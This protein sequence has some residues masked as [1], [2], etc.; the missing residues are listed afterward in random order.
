MKLLFIRTTGGVSGA[1]MYNVYLLKALQKVRGV[2]VHLLTNYT[3]FLRKLKKE[4]IPASYVYNPVPEA[5]TN[6]ELLFSILW[7]YPMLFIYL[8]KIKEAEHG[9]RF[10]TVVLE[11][12]TEKLFLTPYLRLLGYR[13]VW[14]EHGPLFTTNRSAIVKWFYRYKS[15]RPEAIIAVSEDTKKDLVKGGVSE[16]KVHAVHIGIEKSFFH[17][18]NWDIFNSG[19]SKKQNQWTIGFLGSVSKEKGIFEFLDVANTLIQ[20]HV[21]TK[22]IIIGNGPFLPW[23]KEKVRSLHIQKNVSFTGYVDDVK[24]S[25]HQ[26]DILFFPTRHHEG[27]SLALLEALAMGKI[28]LARDI[29]GNRELVIDKKTGF[30]FKGNANEGYTILEKIMTKK[31]KI[32]GIAKAAKEHITNNFSIEKQIHRFIDIFHG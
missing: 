4:R 9:I 25:L 15:K 11:S 30:L 23:A 6:R 27:L 17:Y 16:K 18:R 29:G 5:G 26:I 14:I 28:V 7:F 19:N 24:K 13:V 22:F 8:F 32:S 2:C 21:S 20:K 1:E 12:M 3:P 10:D 31:I